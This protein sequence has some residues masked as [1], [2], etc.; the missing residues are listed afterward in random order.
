MSKIYLEHLKESGNF[1]EADL[2]DFEEFYGKENELKKILEDNLLGV[3][4]YLELSSLYQFSKEEEDKIQE[5]LKIFNS[6]SVVHS[7]FISSSNEV[8]ESK[9]VS[10]SFHIIN[11][12][13]VVKSEEVYGSNDIEYS[14]HI[15]NSAYIEKSFR[16]YNS[17]N[18]Q[19]S[20]NIL[21]S[22]F[23]VNSED[24]IESQDVFNSNGII[25]SKGVSDSFICRNC[26]N[27][28][29]CLFCFGIKDSEYCV[30]N[31]KISKERYDYIKKL[32]LKMINASLQFCE[33]PEDG[34]IIECAPK[35]H[36]DWRLYFEDWSKEFY[37]WIRT[38]PMYD[39]KI[40]L[41]ITGISDFI[42]H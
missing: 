41:C 6:S 1:S 16:I 21:K 14:D 18:I 3:D 36:S 25:I 22:S 34:F 4:F 28:S 8:L 26:T 40:M 29:N 27:I 20:C 30:F 9:E 33:W 10:N 24:V 38:L 31:T 13:N 7:C 23:V 11:S 5:I 2:N 17:K 12:T 37:K 15:Y 19:E 35:I 39:N 32:Y 42:Y